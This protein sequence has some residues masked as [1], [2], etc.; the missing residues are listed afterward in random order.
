[1]TCRDI[2]QLLSPYI[3]QALDPSEMNLVAS[4]LTKC[5]ACRSELAELEAVITAVQN[6]PVV[7]PSAE[8]RQ[9]LRKKLHQTA[10]IRPWYRQPVASWLPLGAAVA[11]LIMVA[12]SLNIG[13]MDKG[14][15]MATRQLQ[16]TTPSADTNGVNAAG[17]EL[18]TESFTMNSEGLGMGGGGEIEVTA[19]SPAEPGRKPAAE[20]KEVSPTTGRNGIKSAP[21]MAFTPSEGTGEQWQNYASL[22]LVTGDVI[23]VQRRLEREVYYLRGQVVGRAEK[24]NGVVGMEIKLPI[25][26]IDSL[27]TILQDLGEVQNYLID[28]REVSNQLKQ[29]TARLAELDEAMVR[30]KV[31]SG[32]VPAATGVAGTT[33]NLAE[34]RERVNRELDLLRAGPLWVYLQV[35]L[36]PIP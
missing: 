15:F 21:A 14:E 6:L 7:E 34:E 22:V 25:A 29:L 35:E 31:N 19:A 20:G 17:G 24:P 8:F 13:P 5:P 33:I 1:M 28:R 23:V 36:R 4:H 18:I 2:Q 30:E 3:D 32:N 12:Y 11:V 10:G 16:E 26:G 27:V 9:N